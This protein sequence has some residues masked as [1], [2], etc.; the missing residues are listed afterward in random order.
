MKELPSNEIN[1][2]PSLI[3]MLVKL[4]MTQEVNAINRKTLKVLKMK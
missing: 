3:A 4:F 2:D 1:S